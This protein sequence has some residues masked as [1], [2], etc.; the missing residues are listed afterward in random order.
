MGKQINDRFS[1]ILLAQNII[2][3]D[4]RS[5]IQ[6]WLN[7]D[8]IPIQERQ[9]KEQQIGHV[10][11]LLESIQPPMPAISIYSTIRHP[12]RIIIHG[13]VNLSPEHIRMFNND[14][15]QNRR[16]IL[17][18]DLQNRLTVL[19]VR[20]ELVHQ[21]NQ[22]SGISINL[23]I[24]NDELTKG[25]L[26]YSFFRIQEITNT[27]RNIMSMNLG[28]GIQQQRINDNTPDFIR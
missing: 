8:G 10:V 5:R 28:T 3:E 18:L 27:M 23:L 21:D 20:H 26:L 9:L 14:W 16:N 13:G 2:P 12:D 19:D 1:N 11:F 15:D 25:K 4:G 24:M 7:E 6:E 17:L 22:F